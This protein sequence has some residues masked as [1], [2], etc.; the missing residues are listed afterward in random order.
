MQQRGGEDLFKRSF[1]TL[2]TDN[3]RKWETNYPMFMDIVMMPVSHI[4]SSWFDSWLWS[5]FQQILHGSPWCRGC[6][7]SATAW[8][9]FLPLALFWAGLSHRG[10]D[11]PGEWASTWGFCLFLS[12]P[13]NKKEDWVMQRYRILATM[14]KYVDS[15]GAIIDYDVCEAVLINTA[16]HRA[17][18]RVRIKNWRQTHTPLDACCQPPPVEQEE[19]RHVGC[20][21]W[22]RQIT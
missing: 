21:C 18:M 4:G 13:G 17:G 10:M 9:D 19:E 14:Y 15:T 16:W 3:W 6:W 8:V 7:L 2:L 12:L 22:H 5:Y 20:Q 11:M 1:K